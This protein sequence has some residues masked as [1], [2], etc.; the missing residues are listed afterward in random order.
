MCNYVRRIFTD[1]VTVC[2]TVLLYSG[3]FSHV[4]S[5]AIVV[6]LLLNYNRPLK[7]LHARVTR[8][9]HLWKRGGYA[10]DVCGPICMP[11]NGQ[12]LCMHTHIKQACGL[13]HCVMLRRLGM[14]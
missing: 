9:F 13:N 4:I 8:P 10:I 14:W 5:V 7:I 1:L 11:V 3:F 6:M 12:I 2:V